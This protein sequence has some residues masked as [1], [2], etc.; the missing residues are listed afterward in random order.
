MSRSSTADG[1]AILQGFD[2][3]KIQGGITGYLRQEFRELEI[4]NDITK[5][6]F[7][8]KLPSNVTG[9]LRSI[10]I[11]NYYKNKPLTYLPDGIPKE[12][13]WTEK[14]PFIPSEIDPN[15]K[16]MLIST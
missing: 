6:K 13:A 3:S 11:K 1:T 2:K 10:L 14:E 7:Y 4:L 9:H 15:A 12:L 16:W 8:G 5:L